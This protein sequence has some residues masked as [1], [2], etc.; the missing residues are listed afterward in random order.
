MHRNT[1]DDYR[2]CVMYCVAAI[3]MALIY[4]IASSGR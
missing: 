2:G 3:I 4:I 1:Q